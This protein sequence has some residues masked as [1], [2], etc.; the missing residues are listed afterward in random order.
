MGCQLYSQPIF[1]HLNMVVR[2][3]F[4]MRNTRQDILDMAQKLFNEYGYN[5][6]ATRDVSEALGISKGNLTY[7]F[8]KKEDIIEAIVAESP[9]ARTFEPPNSLIDLN[10]FFMDIQKTV[11]DK[12]FYFWH[13]A[14]LSQISPKIHVMQKATFDN[15]MIILSESFEI[16]KNDAWIRDERYADEYI[17]IINTLLTISIYWIPFCS[18]KSEDTTDHFLEQIW[19]TLYTLLTPSGIEVVKKLGFYGETNSK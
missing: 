10:S 1:F 19:S 17:Y 9:K 11:K 3:D 13:H 7:H 5:N 15:N 8:K 14:Q 12:A 16:L 4:M 2:K 6:V 18:L